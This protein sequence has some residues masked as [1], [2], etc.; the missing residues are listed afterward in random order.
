[1]NDHTAITVHELREFLTTVGARLESCIDELNTIDGQLGDGDIGIT[2]GKAAGQVRMI[3][4][5][6]PE[7][8]GQALLQVA[9]AITKAR[10]SSYGTLLATGV[11]AMA[12]E[13][14]GETR[15]ET[16]RLPKML[17]AAG[18]KMAA[19]GKSA[20]GEKTVLD[21]VEAIRVALEAR[22]DGKD[23]A[24]LADNA[25]ADAI[26]HFRDQPCRQGRARIFADKSVGIDDPGMVVIKKIT[27][28]WAASPHRR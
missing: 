12:K 21:A 1:M 24:V 4:A 5:E 9:Q 13:V 16:E 22:P 18:A 19:R 6:L 3:V 27:E 14:V 17:A 10:A 15:I 28:A 23:P 26:A 20:L 11:M 25:V 8:L 7:D 2:M